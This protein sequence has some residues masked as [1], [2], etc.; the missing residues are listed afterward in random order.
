MRPIYVA[1]YKGLQGA[2]VHS[3]ATA[4]N[5]GA[6]PLLLATHVSK[7]GYFMWVTQH[8]RPTASHPI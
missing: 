3:A 7:S 5:T 1:P 4:R 2:V 6:N 8:M